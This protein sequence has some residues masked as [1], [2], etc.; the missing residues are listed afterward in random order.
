[1]LEKVNEKERAE[2]EKK[3]KVRKELPLGCIAGP[4]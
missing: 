2:R 4:E 1:M 3:R